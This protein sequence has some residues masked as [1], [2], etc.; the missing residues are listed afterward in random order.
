MG[1]KD[2]AS[3]RYIFTQLSKITRAVFPEIDDRVLTYLTDDGDTVE[4][5]YYIPIIPMILINGTKGIGTGF[6]TDIMSHNPIQIIQYLENMLTNKN[7]LGT[8]EPYYKNF[9]GTILP[10][11]NN[12]K[13]LI[14]GKYEM[15]DNNKIR[16]TELPLGTWTQ[17]YKEFLEILLVSKIKC[18]IKDYSDMSTEVNVEFIVQFYPGIIGKLLSEKH[19]YGLEGIEH[20]LKLST[21]QSTSNMHLFNHKGQLTKYDT[22][23]SIMEEYYSIRLEYYNKRKV[24]LIELLTK[25]LVTLS[26]KSKYITALLNDTIDLR[27]KSKEQI[28][29]L[30][31]DKHFDKDTVTGS[32]NYL[33]KMP[34]DC[35]SE[36]NIQK[37]NK[38]H[39]DKQ[40]ELNKITNSK[41]QDL[42]LD[43][44]TNLKSIYNEFLQDDIVTDIKNPTSKSTRKPVHKPNSK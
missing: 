43:E 20:Y 28:Y 10:C 12:H 30:L 24:Y 15:I 26:N 34:M 4:P 14:R 9:K 38:E 23:Y 6:S 35:V 41:I 1:G 29:T 19:D 42:W 44:L 37:L 3:E 11:D 33:I 8:I 31:E 18:Y 5:V 2:A 32:Y 21:T 25:E 36:E 27:K 17:T 13:Y 40:K 16:I 22:I 7:K 39:D